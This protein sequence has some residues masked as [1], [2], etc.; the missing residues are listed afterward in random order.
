MGRHLPLQLCPHVAPGRG[1]AG[2]HVPLHHLRHRRQ[3]PPDEG[4]DAGPGHLRE[5]PVPP[6][7]FKRDLPRQGRAH[8]PPGVRGGRRGGLPPQAGGPGLP[9]LPAPPGGRRRHGLRR[10]AGEYGA[11]VP[12]VPRRAGV[13]PEPL[14]LHHG[15]RV[16]GHQPRPVRICQ[17]PGPEERQPVRG[18]RRR[19]VHLQI[20]GGHHREH[21]ELRGGLPRG[22]GG[23]PGAELPLHPEHPG[24]RQ[25][26]YRQQHRAQRQDLVDCRRPGEEAGAPHRGERAGRGRPYRPHHFRGGG[27]RPQLLRLRHPL[28]HELPVPHLR[29]DVRQAGGPPTGSSA[30]HGSSTGKKSGT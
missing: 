24:R 13:L 23:A 4:R 19:P 21:Y 11:A 27:R 5:V 3:P 8:L 14:P 6:G 2:L 7:H 15:G 29:A 18:G 26:G 30:A 25:R 9:G 1:P 17:P 28:P 10:P 22:Q 20:P 16:P 12:E